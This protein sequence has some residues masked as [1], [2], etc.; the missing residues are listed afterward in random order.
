MIADPGIQ[1]IRARFHPEAYRPVIECGPGWY[2]LLAD[3]DAD[4]ARPD[5]D[6]VVVQVKEK[7]A[8]LKFYAHRREVWER[9][10]GRIQLAYA[11]SARTCELCGDPNG[12]QVS[13]AQRAY[14]VPR[15][16]SRGRLYPCQTSTQCA[17][18]QSSA[19]TGC[20]SVPTATGCRRYTAT[21]A[22]GG[23]R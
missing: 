6:Y 2:P 19:T 15:I 8:E 14:P 16:E 1:R 3:L 22:G 12:R 5:N 7:L 13:C 10:G 11:L 4:L 21:G 20:R 17:P 9:M 18:T 23:I